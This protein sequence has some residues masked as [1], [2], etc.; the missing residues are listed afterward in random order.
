MIGFSKTFR[1]K[2]IIESRVNIR[3]LFRYVVC[4]LILKTFFNN[5]LFLSNF[6]KQVVDKKIKEKKQ[7]GK[8][9]VPSK[10]KKGKKRRN[11]GKLTA[12]M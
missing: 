4:V 12:I 8:K 5:I 3:T 6:I 2:Y 1:K 7:E 11:R 9:R 10:K